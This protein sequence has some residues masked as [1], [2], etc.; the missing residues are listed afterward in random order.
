MTSNE[1]VLRPCGKCRGTG[2]ISAYARIA[3]GQCFACSGRGQV[4]V[5]ADWR[6][7]AARAAK[8]RQTREARRLATGE[9]DILWAEFKA[10]HPREA[11]RIWELRADPRYGYAYSSVA[12]FRRGDSNPDAALHI[13]APVMK[14]W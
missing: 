11:A 3:G 9:N 2:H 5:P 13:I 8:R 1:T 4:T 6:E 12:T 10:A 7:R 14:D